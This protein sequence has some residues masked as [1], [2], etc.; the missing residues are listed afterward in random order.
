MLTLRE[1]Y[2][3]VGNKVNTALMGV[4]IARRYM[5]ELEGSA[6]DQGV[7]KDSIASC[8]AAEKALLELDGSLARLK[9]L[10][11]RR[12]GSHDQAPDPDRR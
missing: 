9:S 2:H 6:G 11:Y 8:A 4:S 12:E 5:E 7:I 3:E 10:S 1:Q